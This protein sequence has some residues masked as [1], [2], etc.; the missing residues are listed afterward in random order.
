MTLQDE[1]D[2]FLQ[3]QGCF[4]H[5]EANKCSFP[6]IENALLQETKDDGAKLQ[7]PQFFF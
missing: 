6:F 5:G 7:M 3:S 4:L 1:E 2:R